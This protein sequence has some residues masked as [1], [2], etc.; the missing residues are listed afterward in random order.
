M[1]ISTK[2]NQQHDIRITSNVILYRASHKQH[3]RNQ[4]I[5]TDVSDIGLDMRSETSDVITLQ[6][7]TRIT[8]EK[9]S[10][11]NKLPT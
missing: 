1:E 9:A 10:G 7:T 6:V 4:P 2:Q 5:G 3:V 8:R 11:E